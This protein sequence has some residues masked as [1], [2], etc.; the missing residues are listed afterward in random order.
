MDV[1][2]VT[3]PLDSVLTIMQTGALV[4]PHSQPHEAHSFAVGRPG[5][6]SLSPSPISQSDSIRGEP[7]RWQ[8]L[9][10]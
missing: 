5:P 8:S 9:R 1:L 10:R 4:R 7:Q 6:S 3:A 2:D